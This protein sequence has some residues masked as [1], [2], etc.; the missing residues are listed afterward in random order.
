[1]QIMQKRTVGSVLHYPYELRSVIAY[2]S[3]ALYPIL[4]SASI[5]CSGVALSVSTVSTFSGVDV[6]T[7]QLVML[8]LA[9]SMG[10][11]F[12]RHPPQLMVVLN[13]NLVMVFC[14]MIFPS[15][16]LGYILCERIRRLFDT[17]DTEL[18][19][20]AA[21]ATIGLSIKPVNGNNAPAAIGMPTTL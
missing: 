8:L 13:S 12:A 15:N 11:T 18:S 9:S 14:F 10:F 7:L 19:A 17:T 5:I 20:M 21:L 16:I 1:M 4:A 3:S 2:F 6:S